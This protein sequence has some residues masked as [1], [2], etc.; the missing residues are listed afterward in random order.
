[1]RPCPNKCE[2]CR[3]FVKREGYCELLDTYCRGQE[4]ACE[5]FEKNG[6][7]MQWQR[8]KS[9]GKQDST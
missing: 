1:M 8:A 5:K 6:R 9:T 3:H 2:E 7:F 4:F